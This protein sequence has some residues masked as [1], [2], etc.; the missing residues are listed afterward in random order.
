MTAIKYMLIGAFWTTICVGFVFMVCVIL[1]DLGV[2]PWQQ[3]AT[4]PTTSL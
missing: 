2:K 3:Y 4:T 1:T